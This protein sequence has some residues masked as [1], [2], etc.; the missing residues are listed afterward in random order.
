MNN[1]LNKLKLTIESNLTKN[2]LDEKVRELVFLDNYKMNFNNSIEKEFN[3][4]QTKEKLI[5]YDYKF[6]DYVTLLK[7]LE[8]YW[9]SI[10][11]STYQIFLN[12]NKDNLLKIYNIND[13]DFAN[14]ILI[15]TNLGD[16]ICGE[17]NDYYNS[18][19]KI[20][21]KQILILKNKKE[22]N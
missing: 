7:E 8:Y 11:N 15:N 16:Y 5:T 13:W 2:L 14:D 12:S 6:K 17:S 19:I 10:K 9:K 22:P 21:L 4:I 18:Y 20:P 1:V 3:N